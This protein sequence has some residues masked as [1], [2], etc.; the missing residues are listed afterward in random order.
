M[1][2]RLGEGKI[3]ILERKLAT[4]RRFPVGAGLVFLLIAGCYQ[5]ISAFQ[6]VQFLNQYVIV[7][8]DAY[9]YFQIAR[10]F[11]LRGW[12]TFDGLHA[13]S[14]IQILWGVIL[15]GVARL[16]GGRI[17]FLRATLVLCVILNV[18]A[19]F[20]L[21]K[22]GEKLY[23]RGLGEFAVVIWAG[24]MFGLWPTMIGMEYSL[25]ILVIITTFMTCWA[26]ISQPSKVS[27]WQLGLLG[28][29]LTL[30]YW[31]RLD[32]AVYSVLIYLL[33]AIVLWRAFAGRLS[34]LAH[35]AVLTGAPL[36]GAIGYV[37]AS[38]SLA[39]T[40]MPI[41][42]LVKSYYAAQHFKAYGLTTALAGHVLWWLEVE[43]QGL[44]DLASS[45]FTP[46][47]LRSPFA[48]IPFVLLLMATAWGAREVYRER[49]TNPRRLRAAQF[50]GLFWLFGAIHVV[51]VVATIGHFA[52]IVQLYWGWQFVTWCLWGGL[53]AEMAF[54]KIPSPS[55]HR[56]AIG[57]ALT[58]FV[59]A[60]VWSAA[61]TYFGRIDPDLNNRRTEIAQWIN[62][63]LPADARI[64]AWNAGVLGYF[65]DRTVVNLDGLANDGAFLSFLESG[66]PISQYL[67]REQINYVVDIDEQDLSMPYQASWDHSS[68]F[69]NMLPWRDVDKLYD[70]GS[71][72]LYVLRMRPEPLPESVMPTQPARAA[73]SP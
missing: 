23:S 50:L 46:E 58:I 15:F 7:L 22:L 69:R 28:V 47:F 26:V 65:T 63:N 24:F 14:G 8:D 66:K 39:G 34:Y 68:T 44:R 10:N 57:A 25:H 33:V 18:L 53:L 3:M 29:L 13:A 11:A 20:L 40:F 59:V 30:N 1:P 51:V 35:L 61:E 27:A 52:H 31:T 43:F 72:P 37:W 54:S 73:H 32:S 60:H 55:M 67:M 6:S 42:G 2:D 70:D 45:I 49:T 16:F 64:G 5:L 36:I 41:S 17:E 19:G 56:V 21:W 4:G 12:A 48:P 71:L 9:Y 38:F 62:A